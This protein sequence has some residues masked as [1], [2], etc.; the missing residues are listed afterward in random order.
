MSEKKNLVKNT[1]IIAIGKLSTQVIS[2]LLLPLYTSKLSTQEYGTYDYITT[3]GVFLLPVITLL[4]EESMFR[5]LIDAKDK[6]GKEKVITQTVIYIIISTIVF[7]ILG[8]IF[9]QII[10]YEY[11]YMVILYMVSCIIIAISNSLARGLGKIKLYSMSNLISG[12]LI[13]LLNI[14]TIAYLKIGVRGLLVS[15]IIANFVAATIV[16]AKLNIIKYISI[17][18]IDKVLMKKM[19]KF[20]IPLIPN[21]VAF[22]IINISDRIIVTNIL[23]AGQNGIY[24]V[25]YKFPNILSAFYGYF[26]VAWK[27]SAS[28]MVNKEDGQQ[29]YNEVYTSMKKMMLA[30]C[31]CIL[32]VMPIAFPILINEQ[33]NEAYIHIPILI[34]ATYFCNI[35]MFIGGIYIA[36]KD[37]KTIGTTTIVAAIINVVVNIILINRIGLFAASISTLVADIFL[38]EYRK[39]KVSKYIVFKDKMDIFN[40]IALVIVLLAYI[41]NNFVISIIVTVFTII[42]S[43]IR[44]KAMIDILLKKIIKR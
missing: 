43:Y 27:E 12:I 20:S 35:S 25:A 3:I 29:Y 31:M 21:S 10:D 8:L 34:M 18:K 14:L 41:I 30:V 33:Y 36:N 15:T 2:F 11:K 39:F 22:S 40:I 37:T 26:S 17:K 42:Y 6:E 13:V 23:G 5:F 7:S 24:S 32:A 9:L 44:N 19:I 16:F 28:K 38:C 4:M 1:I